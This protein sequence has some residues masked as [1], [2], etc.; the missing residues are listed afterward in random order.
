MRQLRTDH[1]AEVMRLVFEAADAKPGELA[2]VI[3]RMRASLTPLMD[4]AYG[5]VREASQ[6]MAIRFPK[7]ACVICGA[8][9]TDVG[10]FCDHCL[11]ETPEAQAARNNDPAR[12]WRKCADGR[13]R[14]VTAREWRVWSGVKS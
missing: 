8:T 9:V 14:W 7:P 13:L 11:E 6:V 2:G 10:P 12:R 1:E 4:A 3:S 5:P